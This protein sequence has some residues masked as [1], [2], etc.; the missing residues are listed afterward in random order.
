MASSTSRCDVATSPKSAS[1]QELER[2]RAR[3]RKSQKAMRERTKRSLTH[4]SQQVAQLTE[5]LAGQNRE[6][7]E[8]YNRFLAVSE[9]N[10]H[11]RI[12]KAALQLRLL[13]NGKALKTCSSSSMTL[14]PYESI[15][16]NISPT[17]LSDQILQTF[18]ESRWEAHTMQTAS[19]IPSYPEKPDL[20]ALFDSRPNRV[21]DETSSIVG[22][23]VKSY[24]EI[25]TLPKKIGV[26]FIMY[27]LMKWQVLRTKSAFEAVPEWLR[28]EPIQLQQ[29]HAAW[30][31]R[32]PW[33]RLRIYLIEHGDIKFDEFAAAYSSSFNIEWPYDPDLV[34]ITVTKD[35]EN[36]IINPIYEEHITKL[37]NWTVEGVFRAK[38]PAMAA[39]VDS[40]RNTTTDKIV[41]ENIRDPDPLPR[42]AI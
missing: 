20:T 9:E 21:V 36:I 3:D 25:D 15:P 41:T 18:V 29:R 32:V 22:D 5:A 31:D 28:P 40:Y 12:Q 6:K 16:L 1:T 11:L 37:S 34:I 13:E 4:L 26:H 38:F 23:I 42:Y 33:P 19:H 8:L 35:T 7:N 2:K 27:N 17:C 30:I 39:I 24:T 10:D 14:P